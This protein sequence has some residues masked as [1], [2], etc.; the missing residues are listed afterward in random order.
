MSFIKKNKYTK[1]ILQIS[2]FKMML[3]KT[4]IRSVTNK[5]IMEMS[6]IFSL[7]KI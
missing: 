7:S 3:E 5:E 4:V 6:N 2:L 1:R